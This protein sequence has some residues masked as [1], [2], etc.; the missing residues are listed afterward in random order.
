MPKL[1]PPPRSAQKRSGCSV[2]ARSDQLAVSRNNFSRN[3]IVDR[4]S[5]FACGPSEAATERE[6]CDAGR[7]I[8][9]RRRLQDR[10]FCASLSKSASVA[11][12]STRAVRG[13]RIDMDRLHQRK[14][15]IKRPPSQTAL[16]AML[17]PPPA[18]PTEASH[19]ART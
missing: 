17:W 5:E 7:R 11:P 3:K 12:G 18:P 14:E 13:S 4:Q 6:V 19:P 8:D 9:T 16:P 15:S 1:P 2:S 10:N